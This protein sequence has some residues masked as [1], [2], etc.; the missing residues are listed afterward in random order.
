MKLKRKDIY[1]FKDEVN[2]CGEE[3]VYYR[4]IGCGVIFE[5]NKTE[6][7]VVVSD[8]VVFKKE[9]LEKGS[10]ENFDGTED[11][12]RTYSEA[13][14]FESYG[15]YHMG[16]DDVSI[17]DLIIAEWAAIINSERSD[18]ATTASALKSFDKAVTAK[19]FNLNL[20]N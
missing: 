8:D 11:H 6:E 9:L 14:F 20:I 3:I 5:H 12:L 18:F 4:L 13:E 16:T 19:D 7:E 10:L 2:I 17:E 15:G 1:R